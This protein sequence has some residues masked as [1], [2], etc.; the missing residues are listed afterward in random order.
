MITYDEWDIVGLL[1]FLAILAGCGLFGLI[2]WCDRK[3]PFTHTRRNVDGRKAMATD[4]Q[5]PTYLPKDWQ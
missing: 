5:R 1:F 4:W 2:V 3:N